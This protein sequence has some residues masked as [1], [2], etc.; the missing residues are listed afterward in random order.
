MSLGIPNV[1]AM[2][3]DPGKYPKIFDFIQ[4]L[5][6]IFIGNCHHASPNSFFIQIGPGRTRSEDSEELRSCAEVIGAGDTLLV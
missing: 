3:E 5:W 2:R 1:F 4:T 6:P